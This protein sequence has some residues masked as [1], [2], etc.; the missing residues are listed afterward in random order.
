M[1]CAYPRAGVASAPPHHI[2]AALGVAP[3]HDHRYGNV[4]T[5]QFIALAE[6]TSGMD[7][8]HFFDVWLNQPQ[9]PTSW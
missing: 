3:A 8:G 7:L 6:Q 9:K 4:T 5:A 2:P 1:G